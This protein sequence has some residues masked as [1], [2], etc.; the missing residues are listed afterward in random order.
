MVSYGGELLLDS[1][2]PWCGISNHLSSFS[3]PLPLIF[4]KQITLL[5][6]KIQGLQAPFG[7]TSHVVTIWAISSTYNLLREMLLA[8]THFAIGPNLP[9]KNSLCPSISLLPLLLSS[10]PFLVPWSSSHPVPDS[11]LPYHSCATIITTSHLCSVPPPYP[12]SYMPHTTT[13]PHHHYRT[14]PCRAPALV[15]STFKALPPSLHF[16]TH[17]PISLS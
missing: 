17:P 3:I 10:H 12:I 11:T 14:S 15:I 1:S 7:S 8:P 13:N 6:K 4:K 2:S 9:A 16:T 5:M